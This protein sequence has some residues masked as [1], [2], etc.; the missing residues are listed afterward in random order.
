MEITTESGAKYVI[1]SGLCMKTGGDGTKHASF[2]V[3]SMKA[4]PAD[5]TGTISDIY[6]LPDSEPE[7]GKCLFVSGR[8]QWWLSTPVTGINYDK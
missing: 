8:D 4:I 2:M 5:F 6:R 3:F 7:V 1:Q